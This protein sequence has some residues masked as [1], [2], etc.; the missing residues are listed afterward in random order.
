MK[1]RLNSFAHAFRGIS[2]LLKTQTNA[3]IHLA[4]LIIVIGLA[5]IFKVTSV[6]WVLLILT[7]AAVLS[8]EAFNSSI[9]FLCDFSSTEYH[10]NIKK[11]KDLSAAAV[12]ITSIGAL[13]VGLLIFIPYFMKLFE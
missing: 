10:T 2:T 7:S 6:E 1:K 9:E 4:V 3:K 12:L 5:F 13:T 11:T 8:A